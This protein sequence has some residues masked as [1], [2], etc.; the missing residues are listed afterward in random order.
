[1]QEEKEYY[2]PEEVA[3]HYRVDPATIRRLCREGN[4]PGAK[5]IGKQ[6][7]IPRSFVED[8]TNVG[9]LKPEE[10]N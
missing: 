1:M 3:N 5:Q 8:D 9:L 4:V 10:K 7:R 2:T 6:W